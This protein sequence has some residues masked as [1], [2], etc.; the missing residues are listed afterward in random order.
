MRHNL[1]HRL[2]L[3]HR[4]KIFLKYYL[5]RSDKEPV[6]VISERRTGSSLLLSY[7]SSIPDVSSAGEVIRKLWTLS[8]SGVLHHIQYSI[9]NCKHKLCFAKLFQ[10]DLEA[11]KVDLKDIKNHIPNARF[12]ILYRRS[13]LDQFL[14]FRIAE[15]TNHYRWNEDFKLPPFIHVSK[16]ELLEFCEETKNHYKQMLSHDWLKDC[17]IIVDYENLVS[18]PQKVF[19]K[20]IFPFLGLTSCSVSTEMCKQNTKKPEELVANYEEIKPFVSAPC[21]LQEYSFN[22]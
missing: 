1:D 3:W 10:S 4:I 16:S 2:K 5:K 19:D 9:N 21:V 14:S 8:R 11:R 15:M 22:A 12:V 6:F 18:N 20:T 13:L 17:S 7:L